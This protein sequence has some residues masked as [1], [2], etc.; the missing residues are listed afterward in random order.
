[1]H[2]LIDLWLSLLSHVIQFLLLLLSVNLIQ[3]KAF[4][5]TEVVGAIL[6]ST[7]CTA[8]N[9]WVIHKLRKNYFP[10]STSIAPPSQ[11]LILQILPK[12]P[13]RNLCLLPICSTWALTVIH[14]IDC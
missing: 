14:N 10:S 1:M 7:K 6:Q 3:F 2:A 9:I 4:I 13:G 8:K 5:G 11:Q 12:A